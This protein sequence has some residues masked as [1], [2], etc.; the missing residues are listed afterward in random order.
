MAAYNAACGFA[1]DGQPDAA[2]SWLAKSYAEG[3]DV[4]SHMWGDDDLASLR[5][6]PRFSELRRRLRQADAAA[7][8]GEAEELGERFRTV[9]EQY[10]RR[11]GE[12]YALGTELLQA[13]SYDLAAQSFRLSARAGIR[14]GESLYNAACAYA[15]KGERDRALDLLQRSLEAG[16]DDP[17]TLRRDDDLDSIRQEPRFHELAALADGLELDVREAGSGKKPRGSE[18]ERWGRE[19][20]AFAAFAASHPEIG[21]AWFNLGFASLAAGDASTAASAFEK[22]LALR[23]RESATLYNLACANAR[24]GRRDEAFGYLFRAVERGF[25]DRGLLRRDEDLAALRSDARFLQALELAPSD[26]GKK[27]F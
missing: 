27:E 22:S 26:K 3:F 16:F 25:S 20:A 12:L 4:V 9:A 7:K 8:R 13:G 14:S 2:L 19:A 23:Y 5:K 10:P 11:A 24:L 15:L 17:V 6:D 1:R 21:R 18:R